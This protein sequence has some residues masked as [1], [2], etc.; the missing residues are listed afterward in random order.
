MNTGTHLQ[1]GP[2]AAQLA[3]EAGLQQL[4]TPQSLRVACL[5]RDH[6]LCGTGA[7]LPPDAF[8]H[9]VCSEGR[10]VG[11]CHTAAGYLLPFDRP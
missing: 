9:L 7:R 2:G 3:T 11:G 4:C 5:Q 10:T 6:A 1:E 8:P